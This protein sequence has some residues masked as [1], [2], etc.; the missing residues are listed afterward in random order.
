MGSQMNRKFYL[1]SLAIFIFGLVC[2]DAET[3]AQATDRIWKSRTEGNPSEAEIFK[4]GKEIAL[5]QGTAIIAP[6]MARSKEWKDEE[7]LYF[8]AVVIE[9]PV[10]KAVP[11]L[12]WY[13]QNG[14]PW[15]KTCANDLLTEEE[16]WITEHK[17][18]S[19][20]ERTKLFRGWN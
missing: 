20:A 18:M 14:K 13:F 16:E 8:T 12:V 2:A 15:E 10:R 9:L 4:L 19:D 5:E 7:V 17:E 1:I 3:P 11:F 6:I